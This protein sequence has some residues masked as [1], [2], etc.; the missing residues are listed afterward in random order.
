MDWKD[1]TTYSRGQRG[2]KE[3]TAF[4]LDCG[5][6]LRIWISCGHIYYP[7]KWVVK[8]HFLGISEPR[9]LSARTLEEAK[10]EAKLAIAATTK[11]TATKLLRIAKS[12]KA[13]NTTEGDA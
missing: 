12:L 5:N 8:C 2:V 11:D 7:G 4:E 1:V 13:Q 6:G 3:P 9:E 10:T